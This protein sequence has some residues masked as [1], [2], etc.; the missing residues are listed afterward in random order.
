MVNAVDIDFV[1][2]EEVE[3]VHDIIAL[4]PFFLGRRGALWLVVVVVVVVVVV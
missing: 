2:S 3:C 4:F 1:I